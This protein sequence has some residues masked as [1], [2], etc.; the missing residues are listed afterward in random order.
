LDVTKKATFWNAAKWNGTKLNAARW[1]GAKP[2]GF[3]SVRRKSNG[4]KLNGIYGSSSATKKHFSTTSKIL[5][6]LQPAASSEYVRSR[7]ALSELSANAADTRVFGGQAKKLTSEFFHRHRPEEHA[8]DFERL[9]KGDREQD[10]QPGKPRWLFPAS[11]YF[12]SS[13]GLAASEK[14][15]KCFAIADPEKQQTI[16]R[17]YGTRRGREALL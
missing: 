5:V 7:N 6:R 10:Q 14:K 3:Q 9:L 15:S 8:G 13:S 1:N 16:T 11:T 17:R 12:P 4:A 2:N